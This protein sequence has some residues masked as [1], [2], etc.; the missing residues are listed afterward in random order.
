VA[1]ARY[2]A[3][4]SIAASSHGL[5]QNPAVKPPA[6]SFLAHQSLFEER[7]QVTR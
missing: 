3:A 4:H 2:R 7:P 6:D 5:R 1:H